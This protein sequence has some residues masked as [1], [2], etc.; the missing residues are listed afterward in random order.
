MKKTCFFGEKMNESIG[1]QLIMKLQKHKNKKITLDELQAF[2]SG[3]TQYIDFAG[4]VIQLEEQAVLMR[5]KSAGVNTKRPSLS[6]AYIIARSYLNQDQ[7]EIL[8]NKELE[9]DARISLE[10]YYQLPLEDFQRDLPMIEK[11]HQYIQECGLPENSVY[12]QKLSFDLSGD[13]KWLQ[14]K[15]GLKILKRI[16]LEKYFQPAYLYEPIA[17][18]LN[19]E[20]VQDIEQKHLIIENKFPYIE[21]IGPVKGSPFTTLIYGSGWQ[22]VSSLP[23]FKEQ[24]PT[25]AKERFFYFGDLDHAGIQIFYTLKKQQNIQLALPFYRALLQEKPSKG[26]EN[27]RANKD[28]VDEFIQWFS[29]E[30]QEIIVEN[31]KGGYYYP[32]E[33]LNQEQLIGIIN[34]M[35]W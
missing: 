32:Q 19:L 10:K 3:D 9:L 30:E 20:C 11:I 22:I 5:I 31:L 29:K 18:T 1:K 23:H 33:L 8:K 12:I 4:G 26:K 25:K 2:V 27:Q 7:K 21:L 34:G 15:E 13:E 6:N 24:Y 28:S 14:E 17:F 16:K 35:N